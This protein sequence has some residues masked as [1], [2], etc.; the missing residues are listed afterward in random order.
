MKIIEFLSD[1]AATFVIVFIVSMIVSYVYSFI[2]HG[3]GKIDWDVSF[4]LATIFGIV[5]PAIKIREK[6]QKN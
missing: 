2:A 4:Q 5:F 3:A 6:H 1:F